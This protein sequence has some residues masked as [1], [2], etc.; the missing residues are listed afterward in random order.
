MTM[1]RLEAFVRTDI[2]EDFSA[3]R[4][5]N[6]HVFANIMIDQKYAV[7][8]Q[9]FEAADYKGEASIVSE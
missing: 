8:K 9:Q 1:I 4:K 7:P 2:Y 3:A 5:M 6:I